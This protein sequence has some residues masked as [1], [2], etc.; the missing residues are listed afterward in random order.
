MPSEERYEG[1]KMS[2]LAQIRENRIV[3][4]AEADLR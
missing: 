3:E 1:V 4:S 2:N